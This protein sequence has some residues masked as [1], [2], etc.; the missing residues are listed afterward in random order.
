MTFEKAKR[1]YPLEADENGCWVWQG[2]ISASGYG[3]IW[4]GRHRLSA[5]RVVYQD[6]TGGVVRSDL[7]LDH[8]CRNRSCCN[9]AHLQPVT[10]RENTLRGEGPS[11]VNARKTHCLRG[12]AFDGQNTL[13]NKEGH[14]RCRECRRVQRTSGG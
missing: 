8:R 6:L 13:V 11:A 9:P 5:H 14:R 2:R 7:K 12:H 1:R 4:R 10:S 3:V